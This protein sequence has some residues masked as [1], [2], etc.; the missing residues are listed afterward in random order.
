VAIRQLD[1]SII[2]DY[3]ISDELPTRIV[4]VIAESPVPEPA[5]ALLLGSGLMMLG[6][7][8]WNRRR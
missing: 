1:T 4:G 7:A 6:C 8:V 3:F 5:T 2:T